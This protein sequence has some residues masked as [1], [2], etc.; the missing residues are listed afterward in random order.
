[1]TAARRSSTSDAGAETT[2]GADGGSVPALKHNLPTQLT[3]FVGRGVELS[4]VER[5]IAERRLVTLTGV[6]GCGKTRLAIQLG[7]AIVDRWPDGFWI[8]DLGD[9]RDPALIPQLT[10]SVLGVLIEPGGDQVRALAARLGQR[11]LVVC[12]DTCEHLLD[13]A[14]TLADALLRHC[15]AVSVL[16]TSRQPLG[17]EGETVWP[18]PP[19]DLADAVRLFADRAS[20]VDP[21]FEVGP[22][23]DDVRALCS[24]LDR[25]PLAVEL[26]AAWVRALSPAQILVGVEGSLRLLAGGVRRTVPRH[27][28][29][30][31][32]M[33]WSHNLL[34]EDEKVFFRRLAVF[35]GAFTLA[36][37]ASVCGDL[38][39]PAGL[40][41]SGVAADPDALRLM[42]R[43]LD[44]SLVAARHSR[45]E[46][47]Y[48]LLDTIRQYAD[49]RLQAAGEDEMLRDRHLDYFLAL[50]EDAVP[51]LERNQ[52]EWRQALDSHH[53]NINAALRRGLSAP[54]D[55]ANRG[56][57]LAAAMARQWFIRGQSAEG[58]DFLNRAIAL[59]A[60]D[61]SALQ[62]RLLAG[63]AM[64]G[65]ISGRTD[66]VA[67]ASE[68]G[69]DMVG[70][71]DDPEARAR[72]L[73]MA[74]YPRFFVDFERC[75]VLAAEGRAAGEAAGDPFARD[76]AAVL[77]GYSL[78]TRNRFDEAT[79]LARLAFERSWPRRDRFCA[80]FA[81]GIEIF[82]A[83]TTGNVREAAAIGEEVVQIAAP[84]RDYFVVGTNTS[85]A[86]QAIGMAGDIGRARAMMAKVIQSMTAAAEADVVG[87]MV[88]YGLLHLWDGDLEGAVA[89]FTQ[90][91][92]RMTDQRRDWTAARCLPGL[93]AA[94]RR[95]GRTSEAGEYAAKAVAVETA[96]GAPY[97]LSGVLAEQAWLMHDVDPARARAL[98]LDVLALRKAHG[99]RTCYVDSL[100]ALAR[101][102]ADAGSHA[103]ATR[104]LAVSEVSRAA[105]GYPRPPV[106]LADHQTLIASLKGTVGRAAFGALWQ[107][108]AG[109]SLDDW[110]A[111]L[112]RGRGSRGRPA[113]GWESLTG[114]ELDV[115]RL[116]REGLSNPEIAARLHV[117]RGTVKAHLAHIYAKLGVA[118]RTELAALAST[119]LADM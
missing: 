103:E 62:C 93:V 51:R 22:D 14:A 112:T 66:L 106:D 56:R 76:W 61:R 12:L 1:M 53:D 50:V 84:L 89:W 111:A 94:L 36:A 107:E 37:A 119:E 100:D 109:R 71:V 104:L 31:A 113:V 114:M 4:D 118:N 72:C 65:M 115:A 67:D 5:L 59:D 64:L 17:V 10:A 92:R 99:L 60:A 96:F 77:E 82:I 54:A 49:D 47:R 52:D 91:V 21:G 46:I 2:A 95:L 43:L 70:E 86:A 90:G 117:S 18:V 15:P 33:E 42:G 116:L 73:T 74:A 23:I 32:S 81:R 30:L 16:A 97:E 87:Y 3:S 44:R 20:L 6:G 9:V 108:G 38:A 7:A 40:M 80:A 63:T 68:R 57:R 25:I 13:A 102:A 75:Q 78:Q 85:N 45:G 110:V 35:S 88:P 83:L 24:R 41:G 11:R 55:Q 29:L 39:T 98:H 28:T 69:L 79:A 58:L 105:M 27:Q 48:R 34:T 8:V 101:L 26:A 19:L